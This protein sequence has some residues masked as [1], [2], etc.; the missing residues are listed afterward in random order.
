MIQVVHGF[1]DLLGPCAQSVPGAGRTAGPAAGAGGPVSAAVG[2]SCSVL[3]R[4]EC[5]QPETGGVELPALLR[6][7]VTSSSTAGPDPV[8]TRR[9]CRNPT[10]L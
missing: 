7:E 8:T 2:A 6:A 4:A 1:A 3:Q 10:H 5:P 9:G